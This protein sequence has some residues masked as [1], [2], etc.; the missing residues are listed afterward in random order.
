M[1]QSDPQS[2]WVEDPSDIFPNNDS[3]AYIVKIDSTGSVIWEKTFGGN[4]LDQA[5]KIVN[6]TNGGYV[7]AGVTRSHEDGSRF[8]G[9]MWIAKLNTNGS[10][11]WSKTYGTDKGDTARGLDVT[12][13]GGYLLVGETMIGILS[14]YDVLL[15]KLDSNGD[16]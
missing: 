16:K 10:E 5:Y 15:Y 13:S 6:G 11:A 4:K 1:P 3:D 9:D 14:G 8:D 12:K 2:G 7:I